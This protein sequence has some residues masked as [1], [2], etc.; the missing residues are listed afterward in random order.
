MQWP[1]ITIY[2]QY[3]FSVYQVIHMVLLTT[4]IALGVTMYLWGRYA[5]RRQEHRQRIWQEDVAQERQSIAGY[6][7]KS[8]ERDNQ[9]L[10]AL[11]RQNELLERIVVVLERR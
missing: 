5:E 2:P 10:A 1:H 8:I 4:L 11:E 7:A 9:H 6:R 3:Y